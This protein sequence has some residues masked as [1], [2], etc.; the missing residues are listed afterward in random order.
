VVASA[1]GSLFAGATTIDVQ[2]VPKGRDSSN[3]P[4]FAGFL[5]IR[6]AIR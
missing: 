4:G 1:E 5:G 3:G 2:G 6:G